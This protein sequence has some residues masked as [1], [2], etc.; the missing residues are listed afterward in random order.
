MS[1]M[2]D[3]GIEMDDDL[4]RLLADPKSSN[5]QTVVGYFMARY[6]KQREKDAVEAEKKNK[7]EGLFGNI[8]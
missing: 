6:H 8:F 7:S 4:E 5:V 2:D 3:L 1:K